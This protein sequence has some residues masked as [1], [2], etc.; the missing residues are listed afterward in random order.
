MGQNKC[1]L[2]NLSHVASFCHHTGCE[3]NFLDWENPRGIF[4]L[5]L[6]KVKVDC[7]Q[8]FEVKTKTKSNNSFFLSDLSV[9]K[10]ATKTT[11]SFGDFDEEKKV[12]LVSECFCCLS[13]LI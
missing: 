10:L 12:L 2:M 1:T 5:E 6:G 9:F 11:I 13:C 7:L 4:F 8:R 3:S